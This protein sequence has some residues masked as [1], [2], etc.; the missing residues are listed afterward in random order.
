MQWFEAVRGRILISLSEGLK[1]FPLTL[2]LMPW[3]LLF[4]FCVATVLRPRFKA[5]LLCPCSGVFHEAALRCCLR[6]V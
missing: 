2:V 6:P 1:C 4:M 3:G 5:L